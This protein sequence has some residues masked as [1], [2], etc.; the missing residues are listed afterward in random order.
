MPFFL[1]ESP[2][3]E[4]SRSLLNNSILDDF[5]NDDYFL[6]SLIPSKSLI[7][8]PRRFLNRYHHHR[9]HPY[10]ALEK[11][12]T[13]AL[14][15]DV[16]K[17]VDFCP[18]INVSEDDQNYYI[19]ADLPG[20]TKDQVKMEISD[21][22][23]F[24]LS[25]KRE[26]VRKEGNNNNNTDN[27]KEKEETKEK[28]TDKEEKTSDKKSNKKEKKEKDNKALEKKATKEEMRVEKKTPDTE[29]YSLVECSYGKFKRQ[30]ILPED[31]D[32]DHIQAKM[33]NGVLAVT[34][35]KKVTSTQKEQTRTIQ[36]Q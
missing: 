5:D 33:E 10:K 16:F 3:F 13:K 34:F 1:R 27:N 20:M 35:Q 32:L 26:S 31:V 24:T 21:D 6:H 19:Q 30:F 2:F 11:E 23:V 15:K 29:K 4:S 8:H 12:L 22:R 28:V 18:K 7:H 36:I 25:G 9:S 14:N 17:L